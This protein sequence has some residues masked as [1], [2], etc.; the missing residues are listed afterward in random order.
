M[1]VVD[2]T[3]EHE[4]DMA[5]ATWTVVGSSRGEEL[6]QKT[7]ASTVPASGTADSDCGAG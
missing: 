5:A 4:G 6:A 1:S 7:F 3:F 2:F